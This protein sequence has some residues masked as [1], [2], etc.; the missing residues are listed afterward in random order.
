[1]KPNI[2]IDGQAGTTGL[3]IYERLGSRQDINLLHIDP[4]KRKDPA[5]RK[6]LLN[7]ADLV[8]LCLPDAAAVE[9]VGLIENP[10]VKVID[11]STAHRTNP[12]WVYGFSELSPEHR[13]NIQASHRVANPGCHATG[14]ISSVYPLV[15]AGI[16]ARDQF[17][18]CFS[19]TGYSGG[20]KKMIAQYEAAEKAESLY[21]PGLYGLTQA[22]KHLPEMQKLCGLKKPPVFTPIVDDYYKGMAATV[23]LHRS[24]LTG[25]ATLHQVW[26]AL[27]D[28]YA[29]EKL[30]HVAPEGSAD[31]GSK[32]YGNARAG[33]N[34]LTLVAAGNDERFTITALFDNLGKGAS[35]A[36]VQNMNI[37]LGFE[38]TAG[39][40]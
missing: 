7:Q 11:A 21:S 39:L 8:F 31:A 33:D 29:G 23:P 3:Q 30:V 5:E 6:K 17:L 10:A 34:G 15:Q 37:M 32:L 9:A 38:E 16:I 40:L 18:T 24:Q 22:H 13:Q 27:A 35:G 28:H 14:F 2:Y 26:Q 36:A 20:G 1:M 4:D 12:D 19:L 25:E